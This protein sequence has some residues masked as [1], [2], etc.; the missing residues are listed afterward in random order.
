M[1]DMSRHLDG[2]RLPLLVL[3]S[4]LTSACATTVS[5]Y[6][7]AG[8][9]GAGVGNCND[10]GAN[11]QSIVQY[12]IDNSPVS[13][14]GTSYDYSGF[15]VDASI[16]SFGQS[17][18]ASK[19]A[20]SS[21]FFM[22]DMEGSVTGL[23]STSRG[24]L[25]DFVDDGGVMLMTG[26]SGAADATFLNDVFGWDTSSV[27]CSTANKDTTNSAGTAFAN[28]A[29]SGQPNALELASRLAAVER[30]LPEFTPLRGRRAT[31]KAEQAES[32]A[33]RL[34]PGRV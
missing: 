19:L 10:E 17:D 32:I 21:F 15:S 30:D 34:L 16:T 18:L 26:T 33:N 9:N 29:S 1:G 31:R 27:T 23:D 3:L 2:R 28:G 22:T 25:E 4:A 7:Q 12:L 11:L 14:G 13:I 20:A 5:V 6:N 24:I 8:L